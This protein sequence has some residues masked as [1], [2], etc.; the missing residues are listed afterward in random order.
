MVRMMPLG[1]WPYSATYA[2]SIR[3]IS[4]SA[5]RSRCDLGSETRPLR[6]WCG[7]AS[8]DD[9]AVRDDTGGDAMGGADEELP[10]RPLAPPPLAP[11]LRTPPPVERDDAPGEEQLVL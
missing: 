10:A 1:I 6:S 5:S 3:S 11:P 9:G 8:G 7:E 2:A 4:R